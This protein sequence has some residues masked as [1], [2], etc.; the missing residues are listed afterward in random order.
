MTRGAPIGKPLSA[1]C[2]TISTSGNVQPIL[3]VAAFAAGGFVERL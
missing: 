3:F 1:S 2:S